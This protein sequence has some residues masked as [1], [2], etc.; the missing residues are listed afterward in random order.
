MMNYKYITFQLFNREELLPLATAAPA[1]SAVLG[2][3]KELLTR[4]PQGARTRQGSSGVNDADGR[5][6]AMVPGARS[7]L[8]S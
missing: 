4:C 3:A 8:H 2:S 7:S 1:M 6:R 5:R